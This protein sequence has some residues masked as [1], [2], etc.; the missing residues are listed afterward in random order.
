M[1][2]IDGYVIAVPTANKEAYK[3][4]SLITACI[5]KEC[6]ALNLIE[7]WGDDIP[8]GKLTSFPL[9]VDLKPDETVVFSWVLWPDR[10]A[11][12]L[13]TQKAMADPRMQPGVKDMPYDASRMIY[14]GF[15]VFIN[16]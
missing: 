9:A 4:T 11:R 13:G 10:S 12:D 3:K 8:E 14:G 15:D 5:L 7:C 16:A 6:G 1:S 2:Y